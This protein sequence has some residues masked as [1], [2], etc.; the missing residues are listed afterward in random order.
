MIQM[1]NSFQFGHKIQPQE[2]YARHKSNQAS[3]T[4]N[5]VLYLLFFFSEFSI[6]LLKGIPKDSKQGHDQR[7]NNSQYGS[8]KPSAHSRTYIQVN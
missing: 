6:K 1:Q 4:I 2:D 5:H 3:D 8:K 7:N